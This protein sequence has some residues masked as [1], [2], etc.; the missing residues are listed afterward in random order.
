[1]SPITHTGD[2]TTGSL[3]AHPTEGRSESVAPPLI[4]PTN[5][6]QISAYIRPLSVSSAP[7]Q[8][9]QGVDGSQPNDDASPANR[10]TPLQSASPKSDKHDLPPKKEA[11]TIERRERVPVPATPAFNVPLS[12]EDSFIELS[13]MSPIV[14]ERLR[15]WTSDARKFSASVIPAARRHVP[16]RAYSM[17]NVSVGDSGLFG[18][19]SKR[20]DVK[21]ANPANAFRLQWHRA[22][23]HERVADGGRIPNEVLDKL[24]RLHNAQNLLDIASLA[25]KDSNF[26]AERQKYPTLVRLLKIIGGL[27]K[28]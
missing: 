28:E 3:T 9:L 15:S 24:T 27:K 6:S 2:A 11:I 12:P 20:D 13:E 5:I 8:H 22:A 23:L 7:P 25:E 18:N 14:Q 17:G 19:F 26:N 16:S 1:M 4:D 10:T 21:V